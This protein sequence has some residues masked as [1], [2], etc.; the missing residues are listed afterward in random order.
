MS[1]SVG[2]SIPVKSEVVITT[3]KVGQ[4]DTTPSFQA[5]RKWWP[6]YELNGKIL[7]FISLTVFG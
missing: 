6:P 7:E 5:E 2:N 1:F 4:A 3:G